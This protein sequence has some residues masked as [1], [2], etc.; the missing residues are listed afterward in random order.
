MIFVT[1]S[2]ALVALGR[3]MSC[4]LL[5][6]ILFSRTD[7][8]IQKTYVFRNE[9]LEYIVAHLISFGQGVAEQNVLKVIRPF[10]CSLQN[11]ICV[12]TT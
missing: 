11:L 3:R 5:K 6:L 7:L 2:N 1:H 12:D 9:P 4:N 10:I 8:G